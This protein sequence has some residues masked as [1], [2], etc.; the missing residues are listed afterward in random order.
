MAGRGRRVPAGSTVVKI[1]L[2]CWQ[3]P[4]LPLAAPLLP[5]SARGR[6]TAGM[7]DLQ[8]RLWLGAVGFGSGWF[9]NHMFEFGRAREECGEEMA[10]HPHRRQYTR[11]RTWRRA[12]PA[13]ISC[14]H[15]TT[16][17]LAPDT[18]EAQAP[19]STCRCSTLGLHG[20][21]QHLP[22]HQ[23]TGTRPCQRHTSGFVACVLGINK[24]AGAVPGF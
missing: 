4:P 12:P 11:G 15:V 5:S 23:A 14:A 6:M 16:A 13:N 19:A 7:N 21:R 18:C 3:L 20:H 17:N 10:A 24:F 2:R 22:A 8:P 9:R 1:L